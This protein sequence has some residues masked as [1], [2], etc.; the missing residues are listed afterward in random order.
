MLLPIEKIYTYD[1]DFLSGWNTAFFSGLFSEARNGA[2]FELNISI[3]GGGTH[4]NDPF[5]IIEQSVFVFETVI[6]YETEDKIN[7]N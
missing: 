4:E 2:P 5:K 7:K 6:L 3:R 1:D